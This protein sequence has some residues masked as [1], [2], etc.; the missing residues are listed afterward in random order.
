MLAYVAQVTPFLKTGKLGIF[1]NINK[2]RTKNHKYL[3]N[4]IKRFW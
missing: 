4:K 2:Y 3:I 1:K